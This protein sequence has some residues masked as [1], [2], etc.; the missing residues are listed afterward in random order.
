MSTPHYTQRVK[1]E[2]FVF[3]EKDGTL[4]ANSKL[5]CKINEELAT[6]LQSTR[7]M[8]ELDYKQK[9]YFE[10]IDGSTG[11]LIENSVH[12]NRFMKGGKSNE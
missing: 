12:L 5:H 11:D 10:F 7:R 2:M 1:L 6:V 3:S 4:L 8:L 9:V